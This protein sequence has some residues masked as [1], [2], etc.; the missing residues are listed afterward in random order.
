MA[1]NK[2][3]SKEFLS[4]RDLKIMKLR[5]AGVSYSEIAKRFNMTTRGVAVRVRKVL[6]DMNSEAL[7]AYPEL[8]RMELERLDA[9]QAAIWPMTQ[10]RKVTA[11]DGQEIQLEPDV[12]AIQQVLGIM[13]RRFRLLG[14]ERTNISIQMESNQNVNV[15]ATLAGAEQLDTSRMHSAE[16]EARQLLELMGRSGALPQETIRSVLGEDG[17][18]DGEVVDDGSTDVREQAVPVS[19]W[20]EEEEKGQQ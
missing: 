10:H 7:M 19:A 6:E 13:D 12:K 17:I 3:L 8:L 1:D 2:A 16:A 11:D 9:L 20:Q 4:E 18:I 5:Q 15:R 14:M